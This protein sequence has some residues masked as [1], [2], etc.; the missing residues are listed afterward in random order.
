MD[1]GTADRASNLNFIMEMFYIILIILQS[2]VAGFALYGAI[3]A[4]DES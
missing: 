4:W 3:N 1:V 2:M